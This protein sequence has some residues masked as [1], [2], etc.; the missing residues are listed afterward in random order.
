MIKAHEM[1]DVLKEAPRVRTP[2]RPCIGR[3][4]VQAQV[5]EGWEWTRNPCQGAWESWKP[6]RGIPA[7]RT[8]GD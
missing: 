3:K 4:A 5:R 7:H 2:R 1:E 8:S 6:E